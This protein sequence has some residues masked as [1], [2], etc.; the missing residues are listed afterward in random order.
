MRYI[1]LIFLVFICLFSRYKILLNLEMLCFGG[2]T[3]KKLFIIVLFFTLSYSQ[4]D[5]SGDVSGE[6]GID[7]SP[8]NV[9]GDINIP[10]Y[11]SLTVESGVDINFTDNFY[12][13]VSGVLNVNGTEEDSVRFTSDNSWQGIQFNYSTGE[14]YLDYCEISNTNDK[15]ISTYYSQDVNIT[16][17]YIHALSGNAIYLDDTF[18]DV[19]ISN[20]IIDGGGSSTYNIDIRDTYVIMDNVVLNGGSNLGINFEGTTS[21]SMNNCQVSGFSDTGLKISGNNVFHTITNSSFSGS[22]YGVFVSHNTDVSFDGCEFKDN[23]N[24]LYLSSSNINTTITNSLFQNNSGYGFYTDGGSMSYT[25]DNCEFINNYE[26]IRSHTS[27][28]SEVRNSTFMNNN[29]N[30]IVGNNYIPNIYNCKI[31]N[32]YHG[33]SN[34]GIVQNSIISNTE[35]GYAIQNAN[36][37]INTTVVSNSDGIYN[38]AN[39][40]NSIVFFNSDT[41]VQ[42]SSVSYSNIQGG[43]D[44]TGNIDSN[45][46]FYDYYDYELHE[47]SPSIDTGNPDPSYYDLCFPPSQGTSINDMGAYGGP[48][49]CSWSEDPTGGIVVTP[50]SLDF[51]TMMVNTIDSLQLSIIP[52]LYISKDYIFSIVPSGG[53]SISSDDFTVP[54]SILTI[55]EEMGEFSIQIYFNPMRDGEHQAKLL[56]DEVSDSTGQHFEILLTGSSIE[57]TEVSGEVSGIWNIE[58]SPYLVSDDLT[59]PPYNTLTIDPGVE[60]IFLNNNKMTVNGELHANGEEGNNII[61]QTGQDGGTWKGIDLYYST[62]ESNLNYCE[63]SNTNDKAISTYYSQD[64]N[65]TNTYIH[66]LSGNAI[67]LDDTF[68]DVTISNTIIDGG[69]S[70]TYNIDIRDT[71]VIMDNVVLNGGSN[72]GINFEGTTSLSMNNCQVSGFS[73]TGLKISGNN[74]FHTITNSSFSGSDYGV[75]VSH[76]TDVSFDGCE[77]K[78]NSNGLYLSSSNI[79]T[80]IT[81]SLF[82]NNS[83]YGFYTDGGSM[84]YTIDNC[85]F[86]NNYEA[87]RSHTSSTSE[88][89]NSTFM[90][91]NSN[92]IVGNNYIPNIYNCKISNNYHGISNVGIVQNSIISNTENG[93]AIQNANDVI[94]TTVVSNS[95]GIYNVANIIN[96]IVFFNSDTQVQSSSVS[97]S[98][99]QGGYDG[100]GNID[101]N[102]S[103]YDY[104]DYELHESSPSIDTGNPDPSYY[105]LCFPPSQGT[106]IND[107]GA[108]GGPGACEWLEEED[109]VDPPTIDVDISSSTVNPGDTT[110][111]SIQVG[112]PDTVSIFSISLGLNCL[113][114]PLTM[115]NLQLVMP[116]ETWI[117]DMGNE[118]P[119]IIWMAGPQPISGYSTTILTFDVIVSDDATDE[120]IPITIDSIS[121]DETDY[122]IIINEGTI[123]VVTIPPLVPDYGDVSLNGSISPLDA[124]MILQYETGLIELNEQQ[125][126][127]ADVSGDGSISGMD[128]SYILQYGVG[129]IDEFPVESGSTV[130]SAIGDY[131][132]DYYSYNEGSQFE[133][134]VYLENGSDIFSFKHHF[135]Y[136]QEMISIDEISKGENIDDFLV[137]F[138]SEDSE[139]V[140]VGASS[141][142]DGISG[143]FFTINGT[144]LN[145][146]VSGTL[147]NISLDEVQLNENQSD[148]YEENYTSL[149]LNGLMGDLNSDNSLNILDLVVYVNLILEIIEYT[150][151]QL[152]ASDINSDGSIN[153]LDIVLLVNIILDI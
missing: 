36:D 54:Y 119:I 17:T 72:L 79:N 23:S 22:D 130:V 114:S 85:E 93:Y 138:N 34:V 56:I 1:T 102:P 61:F 10:A 39:I 104:Y 133:I 52:E 91:N 136:D 86:I 141:Y 28:T 132:M 89:R 105:D 30:A 67:Y 69:G 27:S 18:A 24:G 48:G 90:N 13:L 83:G 107:M 50:T 126:L 20:T 98:N 87:I 92:A 108:Y 120:E 117:S 122:N 146:D 11:D 95:D 125:Q 60:V 31:S 66:A 80:T 75:F 135:T 124:S 44:G 32:N 9:I 137:Y 88:V 71:Y 150:D 143:T 139:L 106:S 74:V 14:S 115:N 62:G 45:P 3:I 2:D 103:F 129:I 16:N 84:S 21:L 70:S 148:L 112:I 140:V 118:C 46:S 57:G 81:N 53:D 37:V 128:A 110:S 145:E 38:V 121:F 65:I 97:Y 8:Y 51:E 99:I 76:N 15:A 131:Y 147:T 41:Q 64:V 6:W 123:T 42:S 68:A 35:N 25:I 144:I 40:I 100:T 94:N 152:W 55:S 73:D 78:D 29:S 26:A 12:F 113:T 134:P 111:I 58:G 151:Y 153:V 82:Q 149:I 96:S 142:E 116:L 109:I 43:Y 19:T 47:S 33:I 101:S 77:F 4:T 49:A 5:V 7:G 127:N 59:V 63:I